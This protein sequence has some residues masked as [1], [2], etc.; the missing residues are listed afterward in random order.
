MGIAPSLEES[1]ESP[2]ARDFCPQ[3]HMLNT[4][5]EMKKEARGMKKGKAAKLKGKCRVQKRTTTLCQRET[6][7]ADNYGKQDIEKTIQ[8][9][10]K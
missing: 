8:T 1:A 5:R 9:I 3:S 6:P 10:Q 7:H 2:S 4:S